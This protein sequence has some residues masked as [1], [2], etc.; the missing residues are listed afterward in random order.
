M[1]FR[2]LSGVSHRQDS[3][4]LRYCCSILESNGIVWVGGCTGISYL[5]TG[6]PTYYERVVLSAVLAGGGGRRSEPVH[7]TLFAQPKR[8]TIPP[9]HVRFSTFSHYFFFLSQV[10]F[11]C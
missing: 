8:D 7:A 4:V 9:G 11:E 1:L 6:R 5:L 3:L 2:S 10:R